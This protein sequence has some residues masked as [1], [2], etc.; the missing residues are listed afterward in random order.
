M[1]N[2][3]NSQV[4]NA[5]EGLL[6]DV[7]DLHL[8]SS[9][10]VYER[11]AD[12]ITIAKQAKK[13]GYKALLF[14]NHHF[15]TAARADLVA[16]SVPGMKV[17]GGIVLN[18]TVGGINRHAV[19]SAIDFGAKM[20]WMPTFYS[21]FWLE[22]KGDPAFP[23]SRLDPAIRDAYTHPRVQGITI[24]NSEGK[25]DRE[26]YEIFDMIAQANIILSTGHLSPEESKVLV[27]EAKKNHVQKIV[28]THAIGMDSKVTQKPDGSS[29]EPNVEFLEEIVASGAYLEYDFNATLSSPKKNLELIVDGINRFGSANCII[30]SDLGQPGNPN[31]IEGMRLFIEYL[32]DNGISEREIVTL[33]KENPAKLLGLA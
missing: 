17:Y 33:A 16:R 2:R 18:S 21:K 8:H 3:M 27:A 25:L 6:Q 31:P 28:F 11:Y 26:L 32:I 20:V 22:I 15:P 29:Q 4:E 12:E 7:C 1:R 14:K 23:Y 19:S 24:L 9:P 13:A 5:R 30:T 10:D